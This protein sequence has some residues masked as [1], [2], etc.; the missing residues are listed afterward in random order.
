MFKMKQ[1]VTP[2]EF[3]DFD[4]EHQYYYRPEWREYRTRKVRD[5]SECECCGNR[6]FLGWIEEQTPIGDPYRYVYQRP[7]VPFGAAK[8][9]TAKMVDTLNESNVLTM[10][11]MNKSTKNQRNDRKL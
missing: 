1:Y 3:A 5:Y 8:A 11:L 2:G 6:E 4:E 7:F 9:M 10:R